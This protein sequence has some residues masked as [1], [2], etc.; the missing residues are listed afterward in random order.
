MARNTSYEVTKRYEDKAMKR[1]TI[2]FHRISDRDVISAI[3][4]NS[5]KTDYIRRCIRAN[6][7]ERNT[8][9][10]ISIKKE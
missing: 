5:N 1:Y 10:T 3:E 4:S 6:I 8:N 9:N 2:K 7:S